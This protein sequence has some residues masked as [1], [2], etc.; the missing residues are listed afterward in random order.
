MNG[1]IREEQTLAISYDG[2]LGSSLRHWFN[3]LTLAAAL[4]SYSAL[5]D[6]D[7]A[8]LAPSTSECAHRTPI[9]QQDNKAG[10]R[11]TR[12]V[13][14]YRLQGSDAAFYESG[15]A[16][17]ADGAPN[18]YHPSGSPPGLDSL[19]AAGYPRSCSVLVCTGRTSTGAH[20]YARTSGGPFDGFFVSMTTLM[21]EPTDGQGHPLYGAADYRRYVDSTDIPYIAVASHAMKPFRLQRG[22]NS[23]RPPG[24][25]AYVVNLRNGQTSAAIFADVGTN[26]TLGEGSI[27]LAK[28]LGL[29]ERQQSPTHGGV[30]AGILTI[31]FPDTAA[32]P[33][34]PRELSEILTA[35]NERF[36]AWGGLERVK[37]CFPK[38]ASLNP[39]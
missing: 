24:E 14:A 26:D 9:Y 27:A 34:W 4:V 16:I 5:A 31:V 35:A 21:D 17:D 19:A 38:A 11:V 7:P 6:V 29:T 25:L 28:S 22:I 37:H 18:A 1:K 15:L 8:Q 3:V 10:G 39:P 23:K 20:S 33:P 30:A 13:S 32:V 2:A 12:H 36:V